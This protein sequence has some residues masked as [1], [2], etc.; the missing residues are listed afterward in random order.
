[1]A[2]KK[3][4][5]LA[6]MDRLLKDAGA[7]RVSESAKIALKEALEEYALRIGESASKYAVHAGRKTVKAGDIKLATKI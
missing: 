2:N 3:G 7:G 5:P 6:A 1:M 4:I